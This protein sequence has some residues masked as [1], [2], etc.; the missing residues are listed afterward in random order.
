M[1]KIPV[2][3][4][5]LKRSVVV[6]PQFATAFFNISE[7]ERNVNNTDEADAALTHA[8][9]LNPDYPRRSILYERINPLPTL[10]TAL[11]K[12]PWHE[13]N[14]GMFVKEAH[15]EAYGN[16]V[17][18]VTARRDQY[19]VQVSL[20]EGTIGSTAETAR[21]SMNA[22]ATINGGFF[23]RDRYN[24]ISASGLGIENGAVLSPLTKDG[25]SGVLFVVNNVVAI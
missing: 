19:R 25:G 21:E 4:Q 22:D 3:L 8:T 15:D 13:A 9:A 23:S 18:A 5:L 17:M 20:A 12:V 10:R 7:I 6:D 16:I 14:P 1:D 24:R 11:L 2:A